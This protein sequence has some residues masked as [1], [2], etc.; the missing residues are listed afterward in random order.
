M[1]ANMI[2]TPQ[3]QVLVLVINKEIQIAEATMMYKKGR[4]GY[5]KAL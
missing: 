5:P 3:P 1:P 4:T 2:T